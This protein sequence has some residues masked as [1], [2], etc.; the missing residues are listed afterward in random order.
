MAR[1]GRAAFGR[2]PPNVQG[3][4]WLVMGGF[5][6]TTNGAMIRTL[7]FEIEGV[8]TAFFRGFFSVLFLI[9]LIAT[10]RVIGQGRS[11]FFVRTEV[12]DAAGALVAAGS[13]THRR[14]RGSESA[15]GVP[16]KAMTD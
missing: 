9:P 12:H 16:A 5:I 11:L 8:Q 7:S 1:L 15:A 13:S 4:L 14:R 10:G 6:F 2:L 3:A